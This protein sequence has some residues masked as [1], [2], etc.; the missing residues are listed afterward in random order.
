MPTV[1]FARSDFDLPTR[2]G[3]FWLSKSVELARRLGWFVIDLYKD[4]ATKEN[5]LN[6]IE[7]YNP[8]F[9]HPMGHGSAS[10]FTAQNKEVVFQA[11][12][13][14]DVLSGRISYFLSC[15]VGRELGPSII[16]KGGKAFLGWQ[17]EFT[18]VVES[19]YDPATDPYAKAF[20]DM[21]NSMAAVILRG[22]SMREAYNA[23]IATANKWIDYW[24][25]QDDI[26]A[27]EIIKWL[28]HD[29]EGLVLLGEETIRPPTPVV[30]VRP[31]GL[32]ITLPISL[33]CILILSV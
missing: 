17:V 18:W 21:V 30:A 2:Y 31:T 7:T 5:I 26:R 19:P 3:S 16:R 11:C 29:K 14:D 1:L 4:E 10:I 33:G 25:R 12:I 27:P 15:L 32:G 6:A 9:F 23:G 28:I 22:G 13:N 20:E 8:D 24:S